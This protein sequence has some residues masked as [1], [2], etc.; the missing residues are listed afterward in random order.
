MNNS[1][2]VNKTMDGPQ[3]WL[4]TEQRLARAKEQGKWV[5]GYLHGGA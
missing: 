1:Q 5:M 3:L 4:E 2:K